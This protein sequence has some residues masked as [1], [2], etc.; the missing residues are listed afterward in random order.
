VSRRI[1]YSGGKAIPVWIAVIGEYVHPGWG[2]FLNGKIVPLGYG[3]AVADELHAT[4]NLL[5]GVAYPSVEIPD[6]RRAAGLAVVGVSRSVLE[7]DLATILAG[8]FDF[9]FVKPR[10]ARLLT[11]IA[12]QARANFHGAVIEKPHGPVLRLAFADAFD[13]KNGVIAS[14]IGYIDFRKILCIF[15]PR[16]V[17]WTA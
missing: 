14:V 12:S 2:I 1:E 8:R 7:F 9:G 4:G 6:H 11:G 15:A 5:P 13:F 17:L 16:I 10:F 3:R